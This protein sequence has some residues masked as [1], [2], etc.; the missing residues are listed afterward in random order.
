MRRFLPYHSL[1]AALA[2]GAGIVLAGCAGG[3]GAHTAPGPAATSQ[4]GSG[5]A[6]GGGKAPT[7]TFTLAIP[8]TITIARR[9]RAPQY[10]SSATLSGVL[11]VNG[12]PNVYLNFAAG[13]KNCAV[14][15]SINVCTFSAPAVIGSNTVSLTLYNGAY[16]GTGPSGSALST[17][18]N[19]TFM[20]AE[21]VANV[22]VPL[23]LN[24]IPTSVN[25]S[26]TT[27][28]ANFVTN[29]VGTLALT[30]ADASGKTIVGPGSL[31]DASGNPISITLSVSSAS[32]YELSADG[33][34][35]SASSRRGS[36]RSPDQVS[37]G[38][39]LTISD[40]TQQVYLIETATTPVV[41]AQIGISTTSTSI[42]SIP[43]YL[44]VK[45]TY[46]SQDYDPITITSGATASTL[47]G[48]ASPGDIA[49]VGTIS[50]QGFIF[51]GDG[52][53]FR[54]CTASPAATDAGVNSS[55]LLIGIVSG[56]ETTYESQS[57]QP[58]T[59]NACMQNGAY[60]SFFD[61]YYSTMTFQPIDASDTSPAFVGVYAP[62]SSPCVLYNEAYSMQNTGPTC[63]SAWG[64]TYDTSWLSGQTA[65]GAYGYSYGHDGV[66]FINDDGSA[67]PTAANIGQA[68]ELG[69]LAVR[70][71]VAWLLDPGISGT[72]NPRMFQITPGGGAN[73]LFE[74]DY[75]GGYG[76]YLPAS[77]APR[78]MVVGEDGLLYVASCGTSCSS[79]YETGLQV[80]GI[81]NAGES[82]GTLVNTIAPGV[83]VESVAT[84]T[85]GHIYFDDTS[86][87]LYRYPS[88]T[89]L[90]PTSS[91]RRKA[92]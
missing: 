51:Y 54:G 90:Q 92:K 83:L 68:G 64:V 8:K 71:G 78:S 20:V 87:N 62:G 17:A 58:S 89:A 50:G 13:S 32:G 38:T 40:P 35:P 60:P 19:F 82:L 74:L 84:D 6:T 39:T 47:Q 48:G 37:D 15:Q 61:A 80:Y 5:S 14:S 7:A 75:P 11:V 55:G 21:G 18:A 63:S 66:A 23:V 46:P 85:A 25:V 1:V 69:G 2:L 81:G 41:G 72:V 31:V 16:T 43:N 26:E 24:G 67:G 27:A 30:I 33:S 29:S 10:I 12:G 57:S 22:T 34:V 91:I 76:C 42:S 56:T 52:S 65:I 73:P 77:S 49:G 4:A 36:G 53:G 59:Y 88:T 70:D 9:Q 45:Q 28:P 79:T 3:G 44:Y 86:G